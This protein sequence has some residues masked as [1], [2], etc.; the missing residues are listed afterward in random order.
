MTYKHFLN[1]KRYQKLF[2]RIRN[3]R[4][5]LRLRF[6]IPILIILQKSFFSLISTFSKI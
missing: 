6:F 3:Q 2:Q 4:E 1:K 5:I